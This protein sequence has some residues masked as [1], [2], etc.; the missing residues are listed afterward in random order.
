MRQVGRRSCGYA[1]A[2]Y[3][4]AAELNGQLYALLVSLLPA[5]SHGW[6]VIRNTPVGHGLDSWRRLCRRYDPN[7]PQNNIALLRH[8]LQPTRVA[9]AEEVPSTIEN[10]KPT[11]TPT[12]N[13]PERNFQTL[14]N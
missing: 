3:E 13:V 6:D 10:G 5:S 4:G 1:Q 14:C 11:T 8:I 7:N 9:T 2:G 12:E